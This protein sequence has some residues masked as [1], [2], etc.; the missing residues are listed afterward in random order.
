M[1]RDWPRIGVALAVAVVFL[2]PLA[3]VVS[4]S[5]RP[6]GLP[7]PRA[8]EW[9]PPAPAWSNYSRLFELLPF[10]RYLV[11]SLIVAGLAVPLTLLTASWAGF[12]MAGLDAR[13]REGLVVL[14]V[15]LLMVPVTALWL[16][17]YVLFKWLG[18][19]DS[20]A[21]LVAPAVMGSSPLFVLLYYW[22]FRR[23]PTEL[24]ASAAVDGA[25]TLAQ[26]RR[27]AM[28]MAGPTTIAVSI[29]AFL[30]YWSDFINP[31]LYLK[32]EA[33]YTLPVGLQQLQQLDRTNWPILMAA[34]VVFT[35][36]TVLLFLI[37]QRYFLQ[38]SPLSGL[39]A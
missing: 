9:L 11:N 28:P 27:V 13:R 5:L 17:R 20:F 31:L 4:A 19:L 12:A 39:N 23:I 2:V 15:A 36:P 34:C 1:P 32:S 38:D 3:W 8:I 22:T 18:L 29:L 16:T 30:V 24:F 37:V 25:G 21:A 14:S 7:P 26:W 6:P 35:A 10:A 33:L